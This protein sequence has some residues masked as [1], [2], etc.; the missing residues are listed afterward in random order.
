MEFNPALFLGEDDW[1]ANTDSQGLLILNQPI[2]DFDV[3]RRLWQNTK[4]RI[5]ADGGAN[6]LHDMF[7]GALEKARPNFVRTRLRSARDVG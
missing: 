4:F 2:G 6:H 7:N 1:R 5:C 3:F